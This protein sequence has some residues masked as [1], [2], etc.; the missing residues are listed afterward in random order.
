MSD[1]SGWRMA[2]QPSVDPADHHFAHRLRVRFGETDAMGV[3]HHSAYLLYLEEARVAWLRAIG[4][5]YEAIRADGVDFGVLEA[6]V[7]YRRPLRFDDE[8]DVHLSIGAVTGTTFQVAYLLTVATQVR[9][10]AVTVHGAMTAAG[11]P[12]RMPSW[13]AG[14][15]GPTGLATR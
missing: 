3:V 12:T 10:T 14:L 13:L 6:F 2:L 5:P 11:R 7:R 8:V 4:H 9:A 15:T 1:T